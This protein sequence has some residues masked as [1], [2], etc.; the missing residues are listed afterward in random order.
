MGKTTT[1]VQVF[2]FAPEPLLTVTIE[3]GGPDKDVP[4]VHVHPGGQGIWLAR[5]A[6][7]LGAEVTVCGPFGGETGSVTAHLAR[8]EGLDVRPTPGPANG[9]YV[10]D[11]RD[12][13]RTEIARMPGPVLDRHA[14]DDLYGTA[15][16]TALDA[17][18]CILTG[19]EEPKGV[20]V[21]FFER[22]AS[23]LRAA[24][25]TV[26]A[27]LSGDQARALLE[28]EGCVLKMSDDEL[29]EGGFADDDE[30]DSLLAAARALVDGGLGGVV[31]SRASG[32][33]LAVDADGASAITTPEVSTADHRGAGDSMTAG[34]AVGLARGL[35]LAEAARLGAAAGALN[36]TRRGLGTGRG[37]QIERFTAEV[38]V[39]PL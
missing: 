19:T 8:E 28:V 12:G 14:L 17:G 33:S 31:V 39:T 1:P 24:G 29:V 2:V 15:L 7:S 35:S 11:R 25:R 32:A 23:D 5:M 4:E 16:V 9:A 18:V 37:D 22:L 34:I 27:D 10:H 38:E 13:E 21:D 30:Q 26:V 20:P 36:V 6:E 3:G